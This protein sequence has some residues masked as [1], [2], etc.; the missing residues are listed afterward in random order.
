[1]DFCLDGTC[2]L[3]PIAMQG[4]RCLLKVEMYQMTFCL[5]VFMSFCHFFALSIVFCP[6]TAFRLGDLLT[7][8][9]SSFAKIRS[10]F[11]GNDARWKN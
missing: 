5:F 2:A 1:V 7:F 10:T 3:E 11:F 6:I 9:F 8:S 4:Q